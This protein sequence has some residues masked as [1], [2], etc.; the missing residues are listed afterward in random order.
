MKCCGSAQK[1]A[2]AVQQQEVLHLYSGTGLQ[3][4]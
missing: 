2:V 1:I 3:K 4:E